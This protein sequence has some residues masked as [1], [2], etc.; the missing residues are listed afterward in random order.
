M[1]YLG[2]RLLLGGSD[3]D[4]MLGKHHS[5]RNGSLGTNAEPERLSKRS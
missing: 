5:A 4:N 2:R 3:N 1:D